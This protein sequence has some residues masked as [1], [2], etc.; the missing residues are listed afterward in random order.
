M[1]S[2]NWQEEAAESAAQASSGH[3]G[4]SSCPWLWKEVVRVLGK[5]TF[6]K[7][8]YHF[9]EG[10]NSGSFNGS[11]LIATLGKSSDSCNKDL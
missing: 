3:A 6:C 2:Y 11:Q 10:S 9:L 1:G 4:V 5:P 7:P 8:G